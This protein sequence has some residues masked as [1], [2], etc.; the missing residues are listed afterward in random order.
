M[1]FGQWLNQKRLEKHLTQAK[2]AAA[3]GLSTSY[4]STLERQAGHHITGA[5]PQPTADAVEKIAK[6]LGENIDE[7]RLIA[8]YAPTKPILP[9]GL[10]I[11]TPDP[12]SQEG[13][14][15][16]KGKIPAGRPQ[17]IFESGDTTS[18]D[19]YLEGHLPGVLYMQV[20]GNSMEDA[21]IFSGDMI[22][23]KQNSHPPNGSIVVAELNGEFTIKRY[24]RWEGET[25][26]VA[27]N[28]TMKPH[29]IEV[30]DEFAVWGVV[31][32]IVHKL[33]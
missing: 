1:D 23:V 3:A 11:F 9:T 25:Y 29:R 33:R 27:E 17:E 15:F 12:Y 8:G 5:T 26:L 2:L 30:G 18:M 24:R 19:A 13:A 14:P 16:I 21:R 20:E 22:V 7:V 10:K 6:A 31:T 32:H 28:P 4:I